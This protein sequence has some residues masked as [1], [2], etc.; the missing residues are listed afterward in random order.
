MKDV[1]YVLDGPATGV[2]GS[3]VTF[4]EVDVIEKVDEVI[5]VSCGEVVEHAD[6][7]SPFEQRPDDVTADESGSA[8]HQI[9]CLQCSSLE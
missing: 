1:A 9:R 7:V 6:P 4:D 2:D 5:A 8:G 3:E